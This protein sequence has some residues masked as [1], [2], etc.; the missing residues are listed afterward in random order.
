MI[1]YL[2]FI[3]ILSFK[4]F[5]NIRLYKLNLFV[6]MFNILKFIFKLVNKI[7]NIVLDLAN[8]FFYLI[9][10]FIIKLSKLLNFYKIFI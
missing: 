4:N 9:L 6:L 7:F 5:L 3:C 10:V 8:Y 2:F 1:I